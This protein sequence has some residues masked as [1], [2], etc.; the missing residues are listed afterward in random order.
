VPLFSN[1]AVNSV[2]GCGALLVLFAIGF[3]GCGPGDDITGFTPVQEDGWVLIEGSS[4]WDTNSVSW[5]D[6]GAG[7]SKFAF[8]SVALAASST[9]PSHFLFSANFDLGCNNPECLPQRTEIFVEAQFDIFELAWSPV[10]PLVAFEGRREGDRAFGIYTLQPGG[11]PRR[12]LSGFEPTFT[13]NGGLV[14]FVEEGR[15]A[16]RSFNPSSGGSGDERRGMSG[17]AH[18]AVARPDT[19]YLDGRIAYSAV[20][21][22]GDRRIYVHNRSDPTLLADTVSHPDR[23]PGGLAGDG[24]EDDYP[25][26]SPGGR[27]LAYRSK[28][29]GATIKDAIH[30]TRP[31]AE[32]ENP[33]MIVA[34]EPGQQVT[35]LRWHSSGQYLLAIINGDVYAYPMP[36]P[37]RNF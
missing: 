15:D 33:I 37:Y 8:I 5:L 34:I 27:Y 12:W 16:I 9:G 13:H 31:E 7:L 10:G 29:R 18:P 25:T 36:S 20:D 17:A 19:T 2:A 6:E 22:N 32:P 11:E 3:G 4:E 30:V 14:V 28:I 21:R 1:R 35:G 23:L 26:W 24:S